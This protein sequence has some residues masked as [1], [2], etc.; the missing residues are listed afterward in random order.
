MKYRLSQPWGSFFCGFY[1]P[2]Q[3]IFKQTIAESKNLFEK[4][5]KKQ[6]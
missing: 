4:N 6:N 2:Q 5:E 3:I 1:K